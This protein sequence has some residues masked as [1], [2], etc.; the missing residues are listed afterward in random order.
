MKKK[1][2]LCL[3]TVAL[4]LGLSTTASAI[5]IITVSSES[6]YL[7]W[8][9]LD[10]NS[11]NSGNQLLAFA[12]GVNKGIIETAGT[13]WTM[14]AAIDLDAATFS[15]DWPGIGTESNP[16][17]GTLTS[18]ED[19]STVNLKDGGSAVSYGLFN[20]VSSAA[21][22]ENIGVTG[23]ITSTDSDVGGLV[24]YLNGGTIINC[25][26]SATIT[27]SDGDYVGGLVANGYGTITGCSNSGIINASS[28][29]YAGGIV[30]YFSG[31]DSSS[32]QCYNTGVINGSAAVAGGIVGYSDGAVSQCY[33]TANINAVTAGGIVGY[34]NDI[35][36]SNCYNIGEINATTAGGIV[37]DGV[38]ASIEYAYSTDKT[39]P[40]CNGSGMY[41]ESCYTATELDTAAFTDW[42]DN[43]VWTFSDSAY[44][45]LACFTS[46]DTGDGDDPVVDDDDTDELTELSDILAS[47]DAVSPVETTATA[48]SNFTL[49]DSKT[50][51]A[52]A[53]V[54]GW[55]IE[56]TT[57]D[58]I[59]STGILYNPD[60][61]FFLR[62]DA[63]LTITPVTK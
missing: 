39:S 5:G 29:S 59:V 45:Q 28:A 15:D 4:T 58:T 21:V 55:L 42:D 57:D 14:S 40:I 19:Y 47:L 10:D 17:E 51:I 6:T 35:D 50:T 8:Y 7:S 3:L 52:D 12:V 56:L 24:T 31:T 18:R 26:N 43:D 30:G 13:T 48:G 32:S 38:S 27:T 37:G 20:Y 53:V 23:L 49:P 2:I 16:F 11:I 25:V 46:V 36:V 44:P 60:I 62:A 41:A 34:A 33:N 63:T 61:T 9:N 22:I 54:T 1:L